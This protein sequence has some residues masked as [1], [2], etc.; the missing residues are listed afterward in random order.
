MSAR[1]QVAASPAKAPGQQP[2]QTNNNT[3]EQQL[4]LVSQQLQSTRRLYQRL[5]AH[6]DEMEQ[7]FARLQRTLGQVR[8][9][10][11]TKVAQEAASVRS[12]VVLMR[13]AVHFYV[14]TWQREFKSQKKMIMTALGAAAEAGALP[15]STGGGSTAVARGRRAACAGQRRPVS[16]ARTPDPAVHGALLQ[17][18]GQ[19]MHDANVVDVPP[20]KPPAAA[21]KKRTQKRAKSQRV[22]TT[23]E[24]CAEAEDDL[25]EGEEEE[26]DDDDVEPN[27]DGTGSGTPRASARG[28]PRQLTK[29]VQRLEQEKVELVTRLQKQEES[30]TRQLQRVKASHKES[31]ATLSNQIQMLTGILMSRDLLTP[32]AAAAPQS[33]AG[34]IAHT[35]EQSKRL[36]LA[37]DTLLAAHQRHVARRTAETGGMPMLAT[38]A[39]AVD[40]NHVVVRD[41]PAT[42]MVRTSSPA[43]PRAM[44]TSPAK[45]MAEQGLWAERELLVRQRSPTSTPQ[46][47]T[48]IIGS[49]GNQ[50]R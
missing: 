37:T 1:K 17:A 12:E 24:A 3:A 19:R 30:F 15:P 49:S 41:G 9:I 27:T 23:V 28:G 32:E 25:E 36:Q 5:H 13:E 29:A 35:A 22:S 50:R 18:F 48:F 38:A 42:A 33:P 14:N 11:V 10:A 21:S 46:R 16:R 7:E 47:H 4:A 8:H 31:E 45:S 44:R 43:A 2:P 26:A 34:P 6:N 40:R 39:R 20:P